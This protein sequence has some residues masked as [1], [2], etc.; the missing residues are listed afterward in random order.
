MTIFHVVLSLLLP[1]MI[2]PQLA[3]DSSWII[4]G[5]YGDAPTKIPRWIMNFVLGHIRRPDLEVALE[6]FDLFHLTKASG[7][8]MSI[9][10]DAAASALIVSRP[11][12]FC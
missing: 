11:A 3:A 5:P 1:V 9:R 6:S 4:V 7:Y 8:S 2:I 12:C 10:T